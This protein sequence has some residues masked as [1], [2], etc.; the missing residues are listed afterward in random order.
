M[1]SSRILSILYCIAYIMQNC[2]QEKYLFEKA[3]VVFFG[4]KHFKS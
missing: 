4:I 2:I 1:F 3:T